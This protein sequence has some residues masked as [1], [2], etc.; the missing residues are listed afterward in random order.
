M[1]LRS[2]KP[3]IREMKAAIVRAGLETEDLVERSHVEE[4]YEEALVKDDPSGMEVLR[5]KLE[6]FW[7]AL[8][9]QATHDLSPLTITV[10]TDAKNAFCL[11]YNRATVEA[12]DELVRDA[13]AAPTQSR[14]HTL[15]GR[16]DARPCR[17]EGGVEP[18]A[19]R[20]PLDG[21]SRGAPRA[22]SPPSPERSP[23]SPPPSSPPPAG[24]R[25]P[26]GRARA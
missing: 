9:L 4:R 15:Q 21:A 10:A 17:R 12:F 18:R 5:E 23:A 16:R 25:G 26:A 24:T 20:R 22:A 7:P 13:E 14:E 6:E 11:L 3:S 1:A 2:P 8:S 19:R